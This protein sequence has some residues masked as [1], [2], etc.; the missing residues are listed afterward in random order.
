MTSNLQIR[1]ENTSCDII[2]FTRVLSAPG[3]GGK[4]NALLSPQKDLPTHFRQK[5]SNLGLKKSYT[6]KKTRRQWW[7]YATIMPSI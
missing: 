3:H 6:S 2:M 4:T 7:F 5:K 1:L